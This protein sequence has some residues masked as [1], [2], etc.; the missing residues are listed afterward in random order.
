MRPRTHRY[1]LAR[2]IIWKARC[3][4]N[5]GSIATENK[6]FWRSEIPSEDIVVRTKTI[7]CMQIEIRKCRRTVQ[8]S[9]KLESKTTLAGV[10]S[11]GVEWASN[12]AEYSRLLMKWLYECLPLLRRF[13]RIRLYR[14][15]A[16]VQYS[17]PSV[18]G[19]DE[20]YIWIHGIGYAGQTI[21]YSCA[22]GRVGRWELTPALHVEEAPNTMIN[23]KVL[24]KT[25]ACVIQ[26]FGCFS[27][28]HSF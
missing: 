21:K 18:R 20:F 3:F 5:T 27:P 23:L 22:Q 17:K 10:I 11:D 13:S 15:K 24:L 8:T 14:K 26:S 12:H 4:D 7:E 1:A 19:I 6:P 9:H 28:C 25:F 2:K 16:M